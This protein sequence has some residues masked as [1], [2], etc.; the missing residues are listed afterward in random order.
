MIYE[1]AHF[2]SA[3]LILRRGGHINRSD[4]DVYH[5][6]SDNFDEFKL[7]YERYGCSLVQHQDGFYFLIS[8]GSAIRTKLMPMSCVH[9]GTFICLKMR[10]PEIT[11]TAGKL[12]IKGLLV[13]METTVPRQTLLNVYA[14]KKREASSDATIREEILKA[15]RL[16]ED[17]YFIKV[18]DDVIYP[19]EAINRFADV[20]RYDNDPDEAARLHLAI[21]KGILFKDTAEE[22]SATDDE[23]ER[24]D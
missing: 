9:T 16:L 4:L 12:T 11:T 22:G 3:D 18:K 7:F 23:E 21:A 17:L 8:D 15:L 6:V 1:K 10:E 2:V 20:A 19:T 5:F 13:S 14:P 24:N